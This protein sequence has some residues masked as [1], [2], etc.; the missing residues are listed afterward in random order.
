MVQLVP[1]TES[2]FQMYCKSAVENYAQEHVKAGDW[3]PS[4]A[5]QRAEKE[6]QRLLPD[7]LAS[8][9]H[10]FFSI[11]DDRTGEN[12]GMIW[13]AVRSEALRPLAFIYD[14]LIYQE[15]R[16]R[17]YGE[18]AFVQL[19][20]KAKELGLD[21]ISLQVLGHN[22]AAIALYQKAGYEITDLHM[23]KKLSV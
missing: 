23:E 4:D 22:K 5:L 1:M 6:F 7:G 21:K 10:H 14:F 13:F 15:F 11:Q 20:E 18:Q 12:V 3:H 17:G 2:E 19:E 16:R 8:K 9:N